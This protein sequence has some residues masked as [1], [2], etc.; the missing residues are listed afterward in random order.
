MPPRTRCE[1]PTIPN[2][3]LDREQQIYA[4]VYVAAFNAYK[5]ALQG[6]ALTAL[7]DRAAAVA[8]RRLCVAPIAMRRQKRESKT[9]VWIPAQPTPSSFDASLA[10]AQAIVVANTPP[11][12][13]RGATKRI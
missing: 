13:S 5:A 1:K 4:K 7:A 6:E 8:V 2:R 12:S 11:A 3:Y 9:S 10:I